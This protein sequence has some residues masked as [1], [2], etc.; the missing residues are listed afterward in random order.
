[1]KQIEN[2]TVLSSDDFRNR[3]ERKEDERKS[4]EAT[5]KRQAQVIVNNLVGKENVHRAIDEIKE[6]RRSHSFV[7]ISWVEI[8]GSERD[9]T[10][11]QR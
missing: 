2:M 7:P 9:K 4:V 5:S 6:D 10:R 3:G 8:K 1:M 11:S